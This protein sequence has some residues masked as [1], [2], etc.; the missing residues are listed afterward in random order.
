MGMDILRLALERADTARQ[1]VNVIAELMER[2]GQGGNSSFDGVFHYDNG[3][4][5]TDGTETWHVETAGKHYWAA[6]QIQSSYSIS[7]YLTMD[8]P[9]LMH[10]DLEEYAK[11]EFPDGSFDFAKTYVD[12]TSPL[13][14]SG[15]QRRCCSYRQANRS[16]K[17]FRVEDMV[18]LLR[19]HYTKD[20]WTRGGSCVCMHAQNPVTEEDVPCQTT[21]AMI[22]LCKGRDTL[23]WGTG[24][25]TTC[26]APFQ[27]F[28][29]DA[30]SKKQVFS[31]ENLEASH[32]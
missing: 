21:S 15:M 14:Q 23:M 6:K 3:Y 7:N 17:N 12:W 1:A 24:M 8:Q 31:Y 10:K 26:I 18:E 9:D 2:Y 29:F 25:S 30:Y 20:L 22:A 13:N 27:P 4:L 19:S 11:K 32:G 16:S 5:I 28:W